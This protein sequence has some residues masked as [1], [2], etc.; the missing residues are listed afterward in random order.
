VY[1]VKEISDSSSQRQNQIKKSSYNTDEPRLFFTPETQYKKPPPPPPSSSITTNH[2]H[3]HHQSRP[4]SSSSQN[5]YHSLSPYAHKFSHPIY[6]LKD[7]HNTNSSNRSER[8]QQKKPTNFSKLSS[9]STSSSSTSS[10][11]SSSSSSSFK[12]LT[13]AGHYLKTTQSEPMF[14]PTKQQHYLLEFPTNDQ[15]Q[16]Q[17]RS[18][19]VLANAQNTI[20]S[21]EKLSLQDAFSTFK[22]DLI[23]R[24]LKRQKEIELRSKQRQNFIDYERKL[25]ELNAENRTRGKSGIITRSSCSA[26]NVMSA[27]KNRVNYF[28]V[29]DVNKAQ[30][31][32][33]RRVM[34]AQEIKEMTKKNYSKLPEVKQKQVKQRLEQTKKLNQIKSSIYKKVIVNNNFI[35]EMCKYMFL[36]L[37]FIFI[38]IRQY[39]SMY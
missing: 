35:L 16:Q 5:Q 29:N 22:Y 17:Q 39:N 7:T 38:F 18:S 26:S 14:S 33:K 30:Q 37:F 32:Q 9:S 28:E 27:Q 4:Y 31:H 24:S 15:L 10:L 2:H 34:S 13:N 19:H 23:A 25:A 21:L 6:P 36:N 8:D 12:S 20:K 11:S 1:V 3:H